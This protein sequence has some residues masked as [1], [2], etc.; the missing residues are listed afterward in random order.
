MSGLGRLPRVWE[1]PHND[2]DHHDVFPGGRAG[3]LVPRSGPVVARIF[4]YG[5]LLSGE[6]NH[7]LLVSAKFIGEAR[8]R[9]E[10]TF[11]DLGGCPGAVRYSKLEPVAIVG[12]LYAVDAETLAALDR[13]EGHPRFYRRTDVVLADGTKAQT[14]VLPTDYAT[15]PAIPSGSWRAHIGKKRDANHNERRPKV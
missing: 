8:T 1:L 13:L 9:P 6:P 4:V 3:K 10:F 12:E 7:R 11:H 5:T 14:Y 15:R 2:P